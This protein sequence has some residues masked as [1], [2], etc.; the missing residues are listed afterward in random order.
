ML[1]FT[2]SKLNLLILV[3]AL[4][5]IISFFM[6]TLTTGVVSKLAQE[7][8]NKH[9]TSIQG[10]LYGGDACYN[11][12]IVVPECIEYFGGITPAR[13]FYYVMYIK[14][15]P[16]EGAVEGKL[17]TLI[18]QIASRTDKTKIIATSSFDVNAEI[19]LFDWDPRTSTLME[20]DTIMIDP[21]SGG[22]IKDTAVFYKEVFGGKKYL[23]II[24]C[25]SS[26]GV[27]E[28]NKAWAS[29]WLSP[30]KAES[31]LGCSGRAKV[32]GCLPKPEE[33]STRGVSCG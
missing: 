2:L 4:F 9:S 33:C 27:C 20:S 23:H 19:L 21:E 15:Y 25:S 17:N 28:S 13:C 10:V 18:L 24:A 31:W 16:P 30:N 12:S 22:T 7:E 3:T 29:C 5:A 14:R 26:K 32:S 11:S 8:L 6:F 1:G